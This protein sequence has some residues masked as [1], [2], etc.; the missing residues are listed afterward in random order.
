[1][2][3]ETV[4]I[5]ETTKTGSNIVEAG[6]YLVEMPDD[7]EANLVTAEDLNFDPQ[8]SIVEQVA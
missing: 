2:K 8:L 5:E 3:T 7:Y 6:T 4:I 1:M